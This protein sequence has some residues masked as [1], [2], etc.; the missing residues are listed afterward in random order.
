MPKKLNENTLKYTPFSYH[1]FAVAVLI[2][3]PKVYRISM[4]YHHQKMRCLFN[5]FTREYEKTDDIE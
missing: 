5:D 3:Y 4:D 1:S 2:S